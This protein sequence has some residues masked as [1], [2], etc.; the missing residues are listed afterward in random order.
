MKINKS[1]SASPVARSGKV[2]AQAS[3]S[4]ATSVRT[5]SDSSTVMG[6]PETELTPKVRD[7]IMTLMAEV[8][9]LRREVESNRRR[10]LEL[11]EL[12][13]MD[14]L[15]PILNRRAFMRELTRIQSFAA[16]YQVQAGLIYFDLD[17]FK[18]INDTYGH[19][20]GDAVLKHVASTLQENI[21]SSDAVGRLGGD[22]FGVILAQASTQ[23]ALT[24]S[25]RLHKQITKAPIAWSGQEISI[26]ISLG[27]YSFEKGTDPAIVLAE[28]D[29]AMY[30]QKA[31]R[32]RGSE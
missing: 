3:A 7:A 11:E 12:A 31:A 17:N 5:L 19:S 24:K 20:A 6:I 1:R 9:T 30:A 26:E 32:K 16:R 27:V 15:L 29:K 10:M 28:A 25:D 13:D 18:E 23:Q 21:R 8:D 22:E 4:A 14:A 2:R